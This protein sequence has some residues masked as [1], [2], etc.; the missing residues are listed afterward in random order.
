[1]DRRK[2]IIALL[3]A[4]TLIIASTACLGTSKAATLDS[5]IA[6][7]AGIVS[8]GRP[9]KQWASPPTMTIDP[10]ASYTAVLE[11]TVGTITVELLSSDAPS[12]V[13]NFVFLTREGFYDNT[14]FHRTIPGFT[15]QGGDPTGTGGGGPGYHFA[16]EAVNRPYTHGVMAMAN[17]GPNTNGSQF[18]IMHDDFPLPPTNTIFGQVVAG[19]DTIDT[20]ATAPRMA[21]GERSSPVNPVTIQS[22]EIIGP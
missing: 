12:T 7:N 14:I 17:A 15:I 4:A 19:L 21:G 3:A 18:F 1:M 13:N 16:N 11:T 5:Q 22:V 20:I 10:G 8:D 6:P 2:T 9:I